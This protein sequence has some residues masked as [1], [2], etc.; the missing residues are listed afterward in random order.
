[1]TETVLC[2]R[3]TFVSGAEHDAVRGCYA[4]VVRADIAAAAST[5]GRVGE[6]CR[7]SWEGDTCYTTSTMTLGESLGPDKQNQNFVRD[8]L[9]L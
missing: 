6:A 2:T 3:I 8:R 7:K 4:V 1:M 9:S 5:N